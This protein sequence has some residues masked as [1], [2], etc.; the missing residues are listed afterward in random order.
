ME[1]SD[2]KSD[3]NNKIKER[4]LRDHE[5]TLSDEVGKGDILTFIKSS[6]LFSQKGKIETGTFAR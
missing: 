2:I 3:E 1:D 6:F 5:H 4:N